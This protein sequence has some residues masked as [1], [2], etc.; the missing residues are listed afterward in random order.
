[1]P[2]LPFL[3][4]PQPTAVRRRKLGGGGGKFRK[5]TPAQQRARLQT[6]FDSIAQSFQDLQT[7]VA[8]IEPEQVIVLETLTSAVQDVAKATA[9]IP[10]LEWLAERDLEDVDPEFGFEEEKSPADAVSRRLYALMSNQ[11]AMEQLLALWS[12]WTENPTKRAASGFGPYKQLF[13]LL[14][15]IRRWSPQDRIAETGVL[16]YWK[17]AV[18]IDAMTTFEVEFWFRTDPAKRQQAY[19]EIERLVQELGGVCLDQATIPEIIYHAALIEIPGRVVQQFLAE[20]ET[21]NYPPLLRSQGV[22]FFRARAQSAFGIDPVEQVPFDLAERLGDQGIAVGA[23]IVAVL[24]GLPVE[25]HEGLAGRITVDDPDDHRALY[26]VSQQQHG[27]AMASLVIH[28]DLHDDGPAL[29]RQVYIRPIFIPDSFQGI[30]EVTPP[31]RL[32]VDLIH[33]AVRRLFEGDGEQ[34]PTAPTVQI[35]SLSLGDPDQPFDR[36]LSPLARLIDWLA[37]EYKVLIIVSI[38]NRNLPITLDP[39]WRELSDDDL[40][41]AVLRGMQREQYQRRPLS[42][43][44]SINCLS[45]GAVHADA[46]PAYEAGPRVDLLRGRRL[47]SPLNTVANGFRRSTKP[48]IL[49]PGGR[50]LFRPD[51]TNPLLLSPVNTAVQPGILTATPGIAPM[52]LNRVRYSCGTSN[53]AALASHCAAL[54][55]ESLAATDLPADCLPLDSEYY[56][57]LLK[58]LVVHGA[59]WGDAATA[60]E[61]AFPSLAGDWRRLSRLKQQ[62]LGYGEV[63]M[64]RCF[65]ST[66]RR[67]TLL[68]WAQL[69]EGGGHEFN[70]PLPPSLAAR[71]ELRRL[72]ATLAWLTPANHKHRNYRKAHLWIDVPGDRIGTQTLELDAQS[73]RRGT[74]EHRVFEGTDAVPFLDGDAL[75]IQVNCRADAGELAVPV[76]YAIAVTLEVGAN[77]EIDIYQEISARIRPVVEVEATP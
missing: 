45:V 50:V 29:Q 77:V 43:A 48:E 62:F 60:I 39:D 70:L 61:R 54:A 5:P 56:T 8:G 3:F 57:V 31:N 18:A 76:A 35:I 72:T 40:V 55:Y 42:P 37:W 41:S 12:S 9:K 27:T 21:G 26:Q 25:N 65:S 33:R 20:I 58:A 47:P 68:G 59:S 46:G 71:T 49:M 13:S 52:E 11:Q 32:L 74:I 23:P 44:E 53:A 34:P 38:G 67:V 66:E 6:R 4:F 64:L 19:G 36:E 15:D 51:P 28:G 30:T 69:S 75:R 10:G 16:T 63:N 7:T 14:R 73:S 2:D 24:D 1:M 17:E 22:M